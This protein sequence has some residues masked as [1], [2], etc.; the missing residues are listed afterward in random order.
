MIL[1]DNF[2]QV[3]MQLE[4]E[5]GVS[6]E[7]LIDTVKMAILSACKRKFPDTDNLEVD[8]D[9]ETGEMRVLAN[10]MVV[11]TVTN[12]LTEI[13]LQELGEFASEVSLGDVVKL[14]VTPDNFG[15][16]AAQT[17]KQ[18]IVQRI[19]EAEKNGIFGEFKQKE[20]TVVNGTIQKEEGRHYLINLGRVE[21]ILPP[22]EQIPNE[23][24]NPKQVVKIYLLE[25]KQTPKGPVIHVSRTHPGLLKYLFHQEIPEIADGIIEVVNVA[26][27]PG[28]RAKV[29]VRSNDSS[30]GA[31]GTCVGHMGQR[32]QAVMR[33]I[34]NERIDIIE[35]SDNA[36]VF[37]NNSLKPA[38]LSDVIII[39]EEDREAIVV[40]AEDQLSLAIGRSGQN[41]RLSSR[42]TG[43]RIDILSEAE[44]AEK[45]SEITQI[46][47]DS[48]VDRIEREKE[49]Q[50]K[51][52][53]K[54]HEIPAD[55]VPSPA[56]VMAEGQP[57]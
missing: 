35:W 30:V 45:M 49:Q 55:G 25:C 22:S 32:I 48:L 43:W 2:N 14:E 1:I 8:I 44:Y 36:R 53:E 13:S 23:V 10:K 52:N 21:A 16:L 47:K 24:F 9:M 39:S 57:E 33:E 34:S 20:G 17:A 54:Q 27:D 7:V 6:R 3:L 50:R 46:R 18:V 31:V 15:R 38:K 51:E 5:R 12:A 56:T 11:E 4:N 26:R 37:I 42:L 41:V 28:K 19:R 40:V 29:A